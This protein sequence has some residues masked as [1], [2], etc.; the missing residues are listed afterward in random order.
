LAEKKSNSNATVIS[1]TSDSE[2]FLKFYLFS[3]CTFQN[4]NKFTQKC[5]N[6]F[7]LLPIIYTYHV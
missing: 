1:R 6:N 3:F 2:Q 7:L 4:E 5:L